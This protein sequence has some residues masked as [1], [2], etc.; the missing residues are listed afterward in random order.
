MS[1]NKLNNN[2]LV[3]EYKVIRM[4]FM[5]AKDFLKKEVNTEENLNNLWQE[6]RRRDIDLRN[7]I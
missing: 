5:N 1:I 7:Y 2:E 4:N 3:K 6:I